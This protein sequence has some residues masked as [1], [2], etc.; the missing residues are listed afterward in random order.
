MSSRYKYYS[1]QE[2]DWT[3]LEILEG[4]KKEISRDN[5]MAERK[6]LCRSLVGEGSQGNSQMERTPNLLHHDT[7][8]AVV[9]PHLGK[10]PIIKKTLLGNE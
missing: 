2:E 5:H 10:Q 6:Q 3:A 1:K 4:N 7:Q 9:W 8:R